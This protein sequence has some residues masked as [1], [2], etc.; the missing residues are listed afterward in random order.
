MILG[1][2][3][4][5]SEFCQSVEKGVYM[6]CAD[7]PVWESYLIS[8]P[9]PYPSLAICQRVP[10][11]LGLCGTWLHMAPCAGEHCLQNAAQS[12]TPKED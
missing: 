8:V 3:P 1:T 9:S 4:L 7:T 5:C 6:L 10:S 12:M 11:S 2:R